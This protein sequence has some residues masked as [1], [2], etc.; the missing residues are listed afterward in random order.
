[1]VVALSSA[2]VVEDF[3]DNQVA[4]AREMPPNS[5]WWNTPFVIR[6]INKTVCGEP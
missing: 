5:A 2:E 6:H 3:W 1:M 4:T